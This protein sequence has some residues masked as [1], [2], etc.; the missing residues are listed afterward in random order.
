M[1]KLFTT[2][3]MKIILN[4]MNEHTE[5]SSFASNITDLYE[6]GFNVFVYEDQDEKDE[7]QFYNKFE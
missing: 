6:N 5:I 4:S 2:D 7:E 3:N 1:N